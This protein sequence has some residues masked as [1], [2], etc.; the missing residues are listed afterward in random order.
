MY[1]VT[2][3]K[4]DLG[5]ILRVRRSVVFL[6]QWAIVNIKQ[7]RSDCRACNGMRWGNVTIGKIRLKNKIY[8][9]N[10]DG[11]EPPSAAYN[12]TPFPYPYSSPIYL[13]W[14]FD[15]VATFTST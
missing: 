13:C 15:N 9:R 8:S 14:Q 7:R 4:G 3:I 11:G 12:A 5:T 1:A 6:V 10:S 2:I